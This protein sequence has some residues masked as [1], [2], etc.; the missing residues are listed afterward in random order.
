MKRILMAGVALVLG[1]GVA[2]AQ[3][4]PQAFSPQQREEIVSILREA[5]KS[6]PTILRDAIGAMQEAQRAAQ[7]DARREALAANRDALFND[8]RDPIRGN[9][10]GDV[11]IVEFFDARCGY[12]KALHPNMQALLQQDGNIRVIMKDLPVLGPNSVTASRALLAAQ[13]QGKY[14]PLHDALLRLRTEPTEQVLQAEAQRAGIDWARLRRDMADPAIEARLQA[15][16]ALAQRLQIEG[17]PALVIGDTLVPGAVELPQLKQLVA[18]A[19]RR[20]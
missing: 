16:I 20:G 4:T 7:E 9:P 11:T 14:E 8:A 19:R 6:D 1:G 5:L 13:K 15:N 3:D 2:L 12:C 18:E 17:T 10:R